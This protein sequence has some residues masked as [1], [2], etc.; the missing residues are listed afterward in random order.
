MAGLNLVEF[1]SAHIPEELKNRGVSY[2]PNLTSVVMKKLNLSAPLSKDEMERLAQELR[3]IA[4]NHGNPEPAPRPLEPA[5]PRPVSDSPDVPQEAT[6]SPE[7]Q[8]AVKAQM[9]LALNALIQYG[10]AYVAEQSPV[11]MRAMFEIGF[12][13]GVGALAPADFTNTEGGA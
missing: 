9:D 12:A 10:S 2:N 1:T 7:Q 6:I 13:Q 8:A 11:A 4:E 5:A 3:G